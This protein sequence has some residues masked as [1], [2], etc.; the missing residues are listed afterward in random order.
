MNK[1]INKITGISG[2]KKKWNIIDFVDK[3]PFLLGLIGII[4]LLYD[5]GFEHATDLSIIFNYYYLNLIIINSAAV[6]IRYIIRRTHFR[7]K[8]FIIDLVLTLGILAVAFE[9]LASLEDSPIGFL[10]NQFW[11]YSAVLIAFFRELFARRINIK[12]TLVNPAQ[13][14]IFSFFIIIIAGSALLMLPT[15]THVGI[16]YIDALFTSTSAVCVTGLTVVDTATAFTHFGQIIILILIQIGGLGIMTFASYFSYFFIGGAS[17]ESQM[18]LGEMTNT[19]KL[20]EVFEMLKRIIIVTFS[21]ELFGAFLIFQFVSSSIISG[22]NDRI[23]FSIFH[24]VSAFCNAGFSTLTNSLYEYNFRFNYPIHLIIAM[25]IILGGIGFPIIF[26]I[27]KYIKNKI[28]NVFR[29]IIHKE[30]LKMQ[31]WVLNINSRIILTTTAVLILF[32]MASFFILEYNNTLA[33]HDFFGKLVT[34]FFSSVT[35]RTAGFNTVDMSAVS[36]P[37]SLIL[38]L[39]MWVGASPASTGGGIKTSSI[40]VALLNIK[41]QAKGMKRIE[42]FGRE[43]SQNSVDRAFAIIILS[44]FVVL[45]SIF[46]LVI[47]DSE[48]D[49]LSIIFECFSAFGTVGLSRG[50]TAS[51]SNPG[52]MIIILTMFVGRV[53]MLAVLIAVMKKALYTKYR[54]PSEEILIN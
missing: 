25:L 46:G 53:G 39:L 11:L 41:N 21:F 44:I 18:V 2:F 33:E 29:R 26:N 36:V 24:A 1:P 13:L 16:S 14:F 40:A 27:W 15:A 51:L 38:V 7:I 47:F 22:L 19:E 10:S 37:T 30:K 42:I 48:K 4:L 9:N 54:Y 17:Y 31:P 50:I 32:G 8:V 52:K 49:L 6:L 28:S 20:G 3:I 5:I 23:F 35:P 34:S 43:I 12:Y 45:A